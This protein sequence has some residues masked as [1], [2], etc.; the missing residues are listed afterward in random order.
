[1]TESN[2]KNLCINYRYPVTQPVQSLDFHH[3]GKY[4][5]LADD[6][7]IKHI[8]LEETEVKEFQSVK[9]KKTG[10]GEVKFLQDSNMIAYTTKKCK[11][12]YYCI[13]IL[14][15]FEHHIDREYN[16]HKDEIT[17]LHWSS[18]Q[19]K[20]LLSSSKDKTCILWDLSQH[21]IVNRI[22]FESSMLISTLHPLEN[23]FTVLESNSIQSFDL[24]YLSS[25]TQK[26][27]ETKL[28]LK[29]NIECR[30]LRYSFDGK[31]ILVTTNSNCIIVGDPT[32]TEND[33]VISEFSG[34]L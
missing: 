11:D 13:R 8:G 10:L 16:A 34:K 7:C 18:P 5:V 22:T 24:R 27:Y 30:G 12:N 26:T 1:M 25:K 6:E 19:P 31:K 4:L 20:L 33:V 9:C 32:K 23:I 29:P 2:M 14:D 28:I 17:G 15:A 21:K 3:S